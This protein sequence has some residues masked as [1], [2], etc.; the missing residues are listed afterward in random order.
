MDASAP[1]VMI[2]DSDVK[3]TVFSTQKVSREL[4]NL[5]NDYY[6]IVELNSYDKLKLICYNKKLLDNIR[7]EKQY[8]LILYINY[9][10]L[11]KLMI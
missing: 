8:Q 5:L 3:T 4:S 9:A 6:L 2:P 7:Y 11:L 1:I 10:Q